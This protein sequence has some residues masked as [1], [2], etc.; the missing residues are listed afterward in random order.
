[1]GAAIWA[2]CLLHDTFPPRLKDLG[3]FLPRGN[4]HSLQFLVLGEGSGGDGPD[5]VLFQASE[6]Q[7]RVN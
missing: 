5:G 2:G 3:S 4:S 6:K 1:M 7:R